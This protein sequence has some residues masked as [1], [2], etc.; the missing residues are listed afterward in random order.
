MTMTFLI[1]SAYLHKYY[2]I[3]VKPK[4]M[5]VFCT[6]YIIKMAA[7]AATLCF[8]IFLTFSRVYLGASS[9]NQTLF[10]VS[11]GALL[12]FIGH[13]CVKIYFL[14]MPEY[15]Y[16]NIGGSAFRVKCCSYLTVFVL[17]LILPTGLAYGI[18]ALKF[19]LM[20]QDK[21]LHNDVI[22]RDVMLKSGC[23]PEW[24]ALTHSLQHWHM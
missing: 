22:W 11:L 12:A 19:Y 5:N 4:K 6:A 23:E 17:C 20:D 10:G 21:K 18:F 24:L 15:Y 14:D 9:L 3:G 13:F 1:V 2:E 7:S 16:T 8:L